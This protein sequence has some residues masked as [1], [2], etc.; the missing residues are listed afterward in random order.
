MLRFRVLTQ[1][2]SGGSQKEMQLGKY[3]QSLDTW[4]AGTQKPVYQAPCSAG[5][6]PDGKRRDAEWGWGPGIISSLQAT[7]SQSS[8]LGSTRILNSNLA[9]CQ[10]PVAHT[11]NPSYS[12]GRNQENHSSKPAQVNSETLHKNRTG[13]VAQG[14]DP[15][16]KP[17]CQKK[18]KNLT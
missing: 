10:A 6:S 13:G 2:H 11:Y 18:K 5:P 3:E 4:A 1:P 8:T 15:E 14:E 7:T 9:F 16:F 12:G 17:Q